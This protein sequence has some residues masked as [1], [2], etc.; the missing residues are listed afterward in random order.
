M[1]IDI[2]LYRKSRHVAKN[3]PMGVVIALQ[4]PT[5]GMVKEA[6][7][8]GSWTMPV[9]GREYPKMQIFTI[10]DYYDGK[11]PDLP[12]TGETLKKAKRELKEADKTKKL[13]M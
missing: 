1:K 3:P 4:P 10:Q 7:A 5:P 8:M 13:K 12:E 6:A 2:S 9:S 11:R